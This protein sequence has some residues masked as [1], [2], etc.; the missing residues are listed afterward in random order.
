M[1]RDQSLL[2]YLKWQLNLIQVSKGNENNV[3]CDHYSKI[4]VLPNYVGVLLF[5]MP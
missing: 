5:G 3:P 2:T 1:V 4:R